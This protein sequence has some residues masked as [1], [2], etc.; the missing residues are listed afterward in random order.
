MRV[1]VPQ[2][3]DEGWTLNSVNWCE[4]RKEAACWP[5]NY[6]AEINPND[7]DYGNTEDANRRSQQEN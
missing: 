2:S 7:T 5:P 3:V 1:W 6:S 4:R